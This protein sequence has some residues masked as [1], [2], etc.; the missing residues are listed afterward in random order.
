M[1]FGQGH[2]AN[3]HLQVVVIWWIVATGYHDAGTGLAG[4]AKHKAV[5]TSPT[6]MTSMPPSHRPWVSEASRLAPTG[7]RPTND[8]S[9]LLLSQR[10]GRKVPPIQHRCSVSLCGDAAD[11]VGSK[12]ASVEIGG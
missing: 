9:A 11:V 6:L 4:V 1:G 7:A 3:H 2:P 12:N 8:R 5:G 10:S